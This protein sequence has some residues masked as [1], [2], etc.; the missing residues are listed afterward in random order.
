MFISFI[1]VVIMA[2]YQRHKIKYCPICGYVDLTEKENSCS[3]CNI[4]LNITNEFFDE[5]CSQ[6]ELTDKNDIEEYVRQL[7]AYGDDNF[8]EDVMSARE[9]AENISDQIDYYEDLIFND[10]EDDCKCPECGSTNIQIVP[11]KWSL[12]TGIFTNATDR[13][14]VNCKH[15]W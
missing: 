6:S 12:L 10:D 14:C 15:K 7:Y 2:K 9:N 3:H 13:V 5:I 11:R 1:E 8:D 4:S